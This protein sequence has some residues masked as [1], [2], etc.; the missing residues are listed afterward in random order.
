MVPQAAK[1]WGMLFLHI[2]K[3]G[4]SF[5]DVWDNIPLLLYSL[6]PLRIVRK[7]SQWA[8]IRYYNYSHVSDIL[9]YI[10]PLLRSDRVRL[11]RRVRKIFALSP[12]YCSFA[13]ICKF[14]EYC[15]LWLFCSYDV[16]GLAFLLYFYTGLSSS[17]GDACE[18]SPP[19]FFFSFIGECSPSITASYR[20]VAHKDINTKCKSYVEVKRK[21][22]PK[23]KLLNLTNQVLVMMINLSVQ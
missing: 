15:T 16:V 17:Y 18:N 19:L 12:F 4:L 10:S 3:A 11:S 8:L 1:S 7:V 13:R 22:I 21:Y 20:S 9:V 6:P 23:V 5:R 2:A 14:S